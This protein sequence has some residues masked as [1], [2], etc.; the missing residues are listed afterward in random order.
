MRPTLLAPFFALALVAA[1]AAEPIQ[2]E[3][4]TNIEPAESQLTRAE[5]IADLHMWR[6]AGLQDLTRGEGSVDPQSYE[7]RR[8]FATYAHLRSSAQYAALVN[9][10]Q[11]N[12]NA[13]VVASRQTGRVA[14][15]TH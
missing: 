13:N 9:Q 15:P 6:L 8:A 7:Y 12:P 2:I 14:Q 5:V 4:P 3:V 1:A 11:Q 10:L